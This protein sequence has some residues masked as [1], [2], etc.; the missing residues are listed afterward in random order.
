VEGLT[1]VC[2]PPQSIIFTI[3][4]HLSAIWSTGIDGIEEEVEVGVQGF[5]QNSSWFWVKTND[6][7]A[8]KVLVQQAESGKVG[9][10]RIRIQ[11][12][13]LSWTSFVPLSIELQTQVDW[14]GCWWYDTE[15]CGADCNWQL[16]TSRQYLLSVLESWQGGHWST[17]S[18]EQGGFR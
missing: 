9:R 1:W 13:S 15:S 7:L 18:T 17:V 12:W 2:G 6:C 5:P 4:E 10:S 14:G 3:R 8:D 11:K 16:L